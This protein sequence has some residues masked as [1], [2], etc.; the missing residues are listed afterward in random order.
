METLSTLKALSNEK[1]LQVLEWLKNPEDNFPPHA[2]V[3][4][5]EHGVCVGNIQDKL[6]L[7]QS[8]TSQYM[9]TLENVGMVIS[10]RI[11]KWTYYR[12]NEEAIA[13]F[14]EAIRRT[15]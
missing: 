4:G 15:L 13:E 3:V 9:S 7:S 14:A 11:G 6:G 2:D 12:R 1:R 10:T 8:T 5:F